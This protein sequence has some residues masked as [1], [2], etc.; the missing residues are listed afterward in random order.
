ME[1]N[2]II[3]NN[4]NNN[5]NNRRTSLAREAVMFGFAKNCEQ[6]IPF[7]LTTSDADDDFFASKEDF[8][9]FGRKANDSFVSTREKKDN[10]SKKYAI[11]FDASSVKGERAYMEDRWN[12]SK[13]K[14]ESV[15]VFG[16][17]DGHGGAAVSDLLM[18]T[19]AEK[20]MRDVERLRKMPR[21]TIREA[22]K[23][24]DERACLEN[25]GK[26]R[27]HSLSGKLLGNPGTGSCAVVV[28]VCAH[29]GKVFIANVGDS[30]ATVVQMHSNMTTIENDENA[31]AT[32]TR[33]TTTTTTSVSKT[34][35][36]KQMA[37]DDNTINSGGINKRR[38]S[39]SQS[40]RSTPVK[41]LPMVQQV[42]T[43]TSTIVFETPDQRPTREDE[44][45]RINEAGGRVLKARDGSA[46]VEGILAV[47]RAFGNAGIKSLV[48]AVPEI[49]EFPIEKCKTVVLCSDGV[50]EVLSTEELSSFVVTSIED[51]KRTRV[52]RQKRSQSFIDKNN[53]DGYNNN[54][55]NNNEAVANSNGR[56]SPLSSPFKESSNIRKFEN[57]RTSSE[58]L[59]SLS[60]KRRSRDNV[61]ALVFR[62]S[63]DLTSFDYLKNSSLAH[64]SMAGKETVPTSPVLSPMFG[65]NIDV[66]ES[67]E[68]AYQ[69]RMSVQATTTITNTPSPSPDKKKTAG[70]TA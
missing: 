19:L 70:E 39:L 68:L 29:L 4:N 32:A 57:E 28:V 43:T 53:N 51:D 61:T 6:Q 50:T 2:V 40:N 66:L 5:N 52:E 1:N 9:D 48:K 8:S 25:P 56:K 16:V 49:F 23:E 63:D 62:I 18:R 24:V 13:S 59:T 55:N 67:D 36:K 12:V 42:T 38:R 14:C 10:I 45:V 26:M 46:R 22:F 20:I 33:T 60:L 27:K 11:T 44:R 64:A 15:V 34:T 41:N 58:M 37:S 69:L 54:N 17:Y 21:E 35:T 7:L 30:K 47:T 65:K 31:T 3:N